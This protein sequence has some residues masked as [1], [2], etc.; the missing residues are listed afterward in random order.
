MESILSPYMDSILFSGNIQINNPRIIEFYNKHKNIDFIEVNLN[1][2]DILEK[3][4]PNGS[5]NIDQSSI[6]KNTARVFC[7]DMEE[8][9]KNN[10]N[11]GSADKVVTIIKD[12]MEMFHDK[13]KNN[14][15][16]E[17]YLL[18]EKITNIKEISIHNKEKQSKLMEDIDQ[19]IKKMGG[20][21]NKGKLSEQTL[22]QTLYSLYP[23]AEIDNTT[24]LKHCGDVTLKREG[25]YD[26]MIESYENLLSIWP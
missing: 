9:L 18:G 7:S 21:S 20:S 6:I 22:L 4:I 3:I 15:F 11:V 8:M 16:K 12:Y 5:I 24:K 13:T 23:Y 19:I 1:L 26:I 10:N 14:F 17:I 25:K 2:I